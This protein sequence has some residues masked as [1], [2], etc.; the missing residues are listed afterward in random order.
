MRHSKRNVLSTQDINYALKKLN[1][2]ETYGYPSSVSFNYEK[3]GPDNQNLWLI[4]P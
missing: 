4:R 3:L 1:V 2:Q